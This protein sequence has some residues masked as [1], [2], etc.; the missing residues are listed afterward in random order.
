MWMYIVFKEVQKC[1][2]QI[3]ETFKVQCPEYDFL[4][5]FFTQIKVSCDPEETVGNRGKVATRKKNDRGWM[6]TTRLKHFHFLR[7]ILILIWTLWRNRAL[8]TSSSRASFTPGQFTS[9]REEINSV[10][11][12]KSIVLIQSIFEKSGGSL[13]NFVHSHQI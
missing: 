6:D 7:F 11:W 9:C 8:M 10:H 12:Q 13:S 5:Q 2:C 3:T 4:T 1:V